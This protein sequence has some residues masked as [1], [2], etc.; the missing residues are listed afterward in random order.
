M[1]KAK[2]VRVMLERVGGELQGACIPLFEENG[3]RKGNNRM[4][5]APDGS[6]WIGQNSH[7]WLGDQGIQRIVYT[8]KPPA[9][10][11]TMNLTDKGFDL[12]FTEPLDVSAATNSENF[13]FR[14]YYYKYHSKYGSDQFDVQNVPVTSITISKD[15]K[16]VSLILSA[17][18]TG[19]VY[20]LSLGDIKT[21]TGDSL[22]N[23]LI[24]YTLNNLK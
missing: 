14:H 17:L 19:Y 3:L 18:K 9:D 10:I 6:L 15:R 1:N 21:A 22:N 7:G 16:K 12:T 23:K 2:I 20:E 8:G 4:V 13:K 5:F 11:Y 24:C